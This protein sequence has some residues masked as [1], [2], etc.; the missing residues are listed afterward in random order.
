MNQ[1][2]IR[3]NQPRLCLRHAEDVLQLKE[4]SQLGCLFRGQLRLPLA[5]ERG[6]TRP[7]GDPIIVNVLNLTYT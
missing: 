6:K 2:S 7:A 1:G 3:Q 4:M 5:I